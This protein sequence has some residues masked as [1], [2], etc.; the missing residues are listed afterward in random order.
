MIVGFLLMA[1]KHHG[2][3]MGKDKA[4]KKVVTKVTS[5]NKT[6]N[7]PKAICKRMR[8]AKKM[9]EKKEEV[10]GTNKIKNKAVDKEKTESRMMIAT[11]NVQMKSKGMGKVIV[12][13]K[14]RV[15]SR[16]MAMG[17]T[18]NKLVE[19]REVK[20][21]AVDKYKTATI[22]TSSGPTMPNCGRRMCWHRR[23]P[24]N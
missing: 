1:N 24:T 17:E 16:Q 21:R 12:K 23:R 2:T 8:K 7:C 9:A 13:D 4:L 14:I 19:M 11:D 20:A 5:K 6:Q 3:M 10:K 18:M 22:L 15:E